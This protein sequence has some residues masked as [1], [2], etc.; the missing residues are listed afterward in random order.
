MTDPIDKFSTAIENRVGVL[1]RLVKK[2]ID[3]TVKKITGTFYV[4]INPTSG[5]LYCTLDNENNED[6]TH[7]QWTQEA[8]PSL[9]ELITEAVSDETL[10]DDHDIEEHYKGVHNLRKLLIESIE[11]VDAALAKESENIT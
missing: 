6:G 5:Y 3:D 2:H 9:I 4:S 10:E 8:V 7:E 11:I 1:R